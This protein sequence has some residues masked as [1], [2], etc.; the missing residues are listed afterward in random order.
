VAR[1]NKQIAADTLKLT[2]AD[3]KRLAQFK[4]CIR[5]VKPSPEQVEV[6]V[7]AVTKDFKGRFTR[8]EVRSVFFGA[9]CAVEM[10]K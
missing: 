5:L 2:L 7:T 6:L 3:Q 10:T 1:I 9:Q 8:E 4:E